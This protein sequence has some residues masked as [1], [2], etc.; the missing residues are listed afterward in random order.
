MNLLVLYTTAGLMKQMNKQET[1]ISS[2]V[3]TLHSVWH[4]GILVNESDSE[5]AW[6]CLEES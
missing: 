4:G 1:A 2:D 6:Q 5:G 3:A